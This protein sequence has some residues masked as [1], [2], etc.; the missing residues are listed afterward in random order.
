[1]STNIRAEISSKNK[2]YISKHRYYEL[3][4]FCRQYGEW[5][6][7]ADSLLTTANNLLDEK[8]QTSNDIS[9]VEKMAMRREEYL[10]KIDM[11]DSTIRNNID[12]GLQKYI[13]IAVTTGTSYE[14]ILAMMDVPCCKNCFYAQYR[15]FFYEL[16]KVRR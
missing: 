12:I 16:D 15:K 4:H 6:K 13:F 5:K 2:Y 9:E 11:V 10:N 8:V 3:M 1:M 7:D 14:K